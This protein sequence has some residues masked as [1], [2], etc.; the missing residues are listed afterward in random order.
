MILFFSLKLA[1]RSTSQKKR[2]NQR[3]GK[4]PHTIINEIKT[5][6]H[7]GKCKSGWLVDDLPPFLLPK[8]WTWTDGFGSYFFLDVLL[9]K[10]RCRKA[11]QVR[12]FL[13]G[14]RVDLFSG[15]LCSLMSGCYFRGILGWVNFFII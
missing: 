7:N 12:R 3:G 1:M 15:W 14:R 13:T 11:E 8:E 9:K 10:E 6:T 5:M 2:I 4:P